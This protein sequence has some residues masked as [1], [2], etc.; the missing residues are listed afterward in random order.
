MIR[1]IFMILILSGSTL[2][3]AADLMF[4]YEIC[5]SWKSSQLERMLARCKCASPLVL[6]ST[7]DKYSGVPFY[8]RRPSEVAESQNEVLVAL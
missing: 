3:G 8:L 1:N 2:S 4:R 6:A 7:A 5:I